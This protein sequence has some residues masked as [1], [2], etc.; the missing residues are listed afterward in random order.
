V[1]P[2]QLTFDETED[3]EDGVADRF[4]GRSSGEWHVAGGRFMGTPA[5]PTNSGYATINLATSIAPA[6]YVELETVLR[7]TNTGGLFFDGYSDNSYKFVALDVAAQKVLIGHWESRRGF[8][9][10]ASF[11][12]TLNAGTDYTLNLVMRG[13]AVSVT[14]NGAFIGSYGFNSAIVDGDLGLYARGG[15]VSFDNVRLRTNDPQFGAGGS[16]AATTTKAATAT[17][18]STLTAAPATKAA[19]AVEPTADASADVTMFY[20]SG[21]PETSTVKATSLSQCV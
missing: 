9:I 1:L 18:T 2:P 20:L 3:F 11:N 13:A 17:T 5:A 10:D 8:V 12:R 19:P 16:S 4:N 6:S 7:T 14:L 21:L 15:V